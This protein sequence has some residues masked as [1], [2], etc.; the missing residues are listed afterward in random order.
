M[1]LLEHDQ[2]L[3]RLTLMFDRART[4]GHV[5]VTMKRYDGRIRP[6]PRTN[7]LPKSKRGQKKAKAPAPSDRPDLPPNGEYLC[8]L[9]ARLKN[10][11]ISSIVNSGDINQFQVAYCNLLRS[12]IDG[13][14]RQKKVKTKKKAAE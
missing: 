14:T 1:V 5:A 4:Q 10:E 12:N 13:L 8:I 9:R 2:F 11:K 6:S 3:S 7:P